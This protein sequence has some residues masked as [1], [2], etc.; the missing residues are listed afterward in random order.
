MRILFWHPKNSGLFLGDFWI[1]GGIKSDVHRVPQIPEIKS[2]AFED[3]TK[4][5][6]LE[7]PCLADVQIF[8]MKSSYL[9]FCTENLFTTSPNCCQTLVKQVCVIMFLPIIQICI[10]QHIYWRSGKYIYICIPGT[11][12]SSIFGFEP[13]KRRPKLHSKT[14]V[15]MSFGFQVYMGVSKNNGTPISSILIGF[16]IINPFWVPLLF[17]TS[18]YIYIW[19][20]KI[21]QLSR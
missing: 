2:V 1:C 20:K 5:L 12:L 6:E 10:I 17:E 3:T 18:I 4:P 14:G 21:H 7:W 9:P 19:Q 8:I 16:S 13:S 15:I 11:C